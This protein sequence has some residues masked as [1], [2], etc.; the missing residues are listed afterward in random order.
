MVQRKT[1]VAILGGGAGGVSAA[2]W[3]S[4]SQSLR[5]R[6]EVSLYT[7]GWRLGGKCASGRNSEHAQRIEEHGLHLFLGYYETVFA[8]L[9][10]AYALTAQEGGVFQ[11]WDDALKPQRLITI[12]FAAPN[13]AGGG[14]FDFWTIDFPPLPGTPG[15]PD[16]DFFVNAVNRLIQSLEREIWPALRDL[17]EGGGLAA[18][19]AA[20]DGL[21]AAGPF[22]RLAAL[23]EGLAAETRSAPDLLKDE[24][25]R[26]HD[27]FH[28]LLAE[29]LRGSGAAGHRLYVL[30]SLALAGLAG[31]LED[32]LPH[33]EAG[34][35]RLDE[36]DFREWL[37]AHGA[38]ADTLAT[39]PVRALYDLA[40]AYENGD[41][42]NPAAARIAAGAALRC[43]AKIAFGYRDAP[44]WK[45][46]AGAGDT[47]FT[48]LYKYLVARQVRVEFFHRVRN[49]RLAENRREIAAI[50]FD[51]Q[52]TL[53][54]AGYH[55]F[56]RIKGLNCW[57]S[58]PLWEQIVDG[59]DLK[60][61]NLDLESE[62]CTLRVGER[63]L[64]L[65]SDFDIVVLAMPPMALAPIS[66][67]L[68]AAGESWRAMLANMAAVPTQSVQ[69]W[70][71]PNLAGTGWS[72]G[73][74]VMTSYVEALSSWAD[75]SHLL[76]R[77]DRAP[78]A[79]PRSCQYLCGV[80]VPPPQLPQG[81]NPGFIP[82]QTALVERQTAAWLGANA[83]RLWPN[84]SP[85]G[86]SLDSGQIVEPFYRVNIDS[87][88]QYVQT[89]PG[90]T[91]FRLA[92]GASGFDNA[93][94]AGDWTLS[95]I[96]GGSVEAAFESG[97]RAAEA[98]AGAVSPAQPD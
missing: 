83:G 75:M 94:L 52:V 71:E 36:R 42:A 57:P 11:R 5:D 90:S 6:F 95:S 89:F 46:Q 3:L 54:G 92:P 30:V 97:K 19:A 18:V 51:R 22:R 44:L 77:E 41:A 66:G 34:F 59:D 73:A 50:E 53:K 2:F 69:L 14:K 37:Q 55:P 47:I 70:L 98:I 49:L 61:R 82:A 15:D 32:V 62:W 16:P 81:E 38:P 56:C 79:P 76:V 1:R 72:D 87:S 45:M 23:A 74:T 28:T 31:F 29:P 8:T 39:G 88:E 68:A 67:E 40:F 58:Q 84:I 93:F 20:A 35:A 12:P 9:R 26:L 4:A 91:K 78:D 21:F 24:A 43:A 33:G 65:G 17:A 64:S 86:K 48:P 10:A 7:Q 63:M 60:S 27:W 80:F 25:K 85:D 96:N 13:G